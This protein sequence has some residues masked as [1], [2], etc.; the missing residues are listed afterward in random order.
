VFEFERLLTAPPRAIA[1]RTLYL[2]DYPPID[3]AAWAEQIGRE[4]RAPRIRTWP[5]A[6]L[7]LLA[8]CGDALQRL[9]WSEPPLTRF[10]LANLVTDMVYDLRP[11]REIVGTLPYGVDAGVRLTASWMR[12]R[13]ELE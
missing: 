12:A 9:G 8:L 2:A 4:I 3:V 6:P 10:R 11:L 7:K 13:G 5:I 1:G